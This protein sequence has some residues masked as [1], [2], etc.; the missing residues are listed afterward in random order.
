MAQQTNGTGLPRFVVSAE[1]LKDVLREL[2][3]LD[4]ALRKELRD[5]MKGAIAPLGSSILAKIPSAPPLSGFASNVG[6]SPYIW[7][8]PRMAV[9]TPFAK[10]ASKPGAAYPVVS[11]QFADRR[12]N[13]ALSI[14]ELAGS[15][16]IGKNKGGLTQRGR[17]MIKGLSTAGYNV[18]AGLGRFAIPEFKTKQPQAERL[19]RE[20]LGRFSAKVNRRLK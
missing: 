7:R 16:N 15:R 8:K 4:P 14:L 10:R 20:I 6:E 13:A 11:L 5:E 3:N 19:A 17:N 9:R 12:P 18:K 1:N 2:R